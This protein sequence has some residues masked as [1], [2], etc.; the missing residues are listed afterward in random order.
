VLVNI[1]AEGGIGRGSGL[2]LWSAG[3]VHR[4]GDSAL[5]HIKVDD[6]GRVR[7]LHQAHIPL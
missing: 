6:C 7:H 5:R 4:S 3:A 1:G 2:S